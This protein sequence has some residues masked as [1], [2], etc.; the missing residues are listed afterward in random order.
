MD[1][2]GHPR[3][4]SAVV[5]RRTPPGVRVFGVVSTDGTAGGL[6]AVTEEVF[7]WTT[8]CGDADRLWMVGSTVEEQLL[9]SAVP[10]GPPPRTP[11]ASRRSAMR[12]RISVSDSAGTSTYDVDLGQSL[13]LYAR[14]LYV[15]LLAPRG[16]VAVSDGQVAPQQ[17]LVFHAQV[18]LRMLELDIS[19]GARRASLTETV[20][21]AAGQPAV[22]RVPGGAVWLLAFAEPMAAVPVWRWLRAESPLGTAIALGQVAWDADAPRFETDVPSATHVRIEPAV[23]DRTFT[24]VWTIAP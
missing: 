3:L 6:L 24:L 12:L 9:F 14:S 4:G 17:G 5:S 13:E 15:A 23:E 11:S 2:C 18:G 20:F 21:I 8:E 22:Q 1:T 7:S 10:V 19:R 16:A